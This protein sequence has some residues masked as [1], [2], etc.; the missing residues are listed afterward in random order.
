M[1]GQLASL[2]PMSMLT[3]PKVL[4]GVASN[5]QHAKL[6]TVDATGKPLPRNDA[7]SVELEFQFNPS[8][9]SITKSVK[10][11][12]PEKLVPARNAP[13]LDFGGG[14]PATYGLDLIFDTSQASSPRDVRQYTQELLRLVMVTG[15]LKQRKPPPRVQ[16]Q[17]GK[18]H[19]FLAVVEEVKLQYTLFLPDGTP[20]RAKASVKLK[21]QDDND[22]FKRGQNPTTRTE[23]RKTRVVQ[24]GER[25][26]LIAYEEYG[27]VAHWRYLAEANHLLNPTDLRSGQIL[28]IPPLP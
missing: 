14:E 13:D 7:R 28:S 2:N 16:L 25:L 17:W 12:S 4:G 15:S 5:L 26:D 20:V 1:A 3:R 24:E 22:D 18:L 10:W 27:A 21:Q 19:L 9:L 6:I 23:T 11:K 8:Q